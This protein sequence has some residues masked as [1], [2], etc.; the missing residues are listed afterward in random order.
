M[1]TNQEL[2]DLVDQYLPDNSRLRVIVTRKLLKLLIV[3]MNTGSTGSAQV[4][5]IT[6]YLGNI[7]NTDLVTFINTNDSPKWDLREGY[8]Y[9]FQY[10]GRGILNNYKY[11]GVKPNYLGSS[12]VHATSNDFA[13]LTSAPLYIEGSQVIKH[14]SNQSQTNLEA[15]D[16]VI[17][18]YIPNG[19]DPTILSYYRYKG[20]D[21]NL[22]QNYE[23][24]GQM[25]L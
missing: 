22:F 14:N 12:R 1:A 2:Y 3:S 23:Q 4:N 19:G 11:I 18:K 9:T 10:I 21:K 6:I 5:D 8:L 13:F 7:G 24:L 16:I 20:G 17:Y 15:N 25:A